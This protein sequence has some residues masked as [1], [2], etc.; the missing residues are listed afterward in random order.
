M[1]DYLKGL[2]E[3]QKEAVLHINGP[4]MIVAGAGSG[5]TKVL[6]TRI[7]HLMNQGVDAFNILALTFTNKA[8]AE[9]KER[10]EKILGN[11]EARNL[12]IG[13]FHSVFARI[14]RGEAHRIGYPNNFTIYDTDDSRSVLKTVINEM[15]LDD[16][17]YKP[18]VVGN[19]IS[20]AKNALVGPAEY[21]TDYYIQQE[22]MRAN[23]P[24][25]AQI[26]AAYAAR[27][28]KNGAMDFDDLLLKMYELLKNFPEALHKYQHKFKYILIDEYQDT[29]A[30]Q[31][32]ITKL[33]AAAHENICVV[34]DD[35]QSIYSFRGA[36]IENILQF[37][38]DYDDV[39]VVKL[40]QN[41]RSSQS[42]LNVANEVISN[43][44]G[45]I[46]K[47]LWTE[48]SA[49]EKISLVRTMT[50]N[51]EG[52]FTADTIQ[53]Q[54]LRNH[55]HN[56]D[57]AILY[58]TNAQSRAFEESLRRM[59]IAYRIYGGVSFYQ[60]K[61]IKD[62][63]AYMRVIVNTNDEVSLLR[64][65]NYPARGIGKTT[66]EKCAIYAN[67]QNIPLFEVVSRAGEFGFKGG[68]LE[69]LSNFVTM[70]RYFQSLLTDKNAYDVAV[71]VGKHT[72][73]TKE[74]FADKTTEGLARYENI[75]E[76]LNSIK[77]WTESPLNEEDG[78][79]GE[80]S[81][82][83]YLQQITLLT[84]ADDDKENSD[85]VKLMTIHAAKGLEFGCVFVAGIEEM[86]FPNAMSINT[87]EELEEERRLFY[88]A[89]TRAKHRLWLT[90]ANTRYR[91]GQLVQNEPSRF[92]EEMPEQYI[93]KSYAGGGA[94]NNFSS[95]MGSAFERMQR[96]FGF[97]S[98]AADAE[99][100][101]G[102]PPAKKT[103]SK[104]EYLPIT[105]PSSKVVE[106]KPGAD[107]V[108]SDT[109]NLQAGQ[110]VE[111]QKFGFG[112]V[113]KVEGSAHNPVA[114]IVFKLNGEKKIMLNYAKLRI[115]S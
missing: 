6:T 54:K 58:R 55:Y 94:R 42:I 11:S 21:A 82:G 14:L 109:S 25:I 32:Q 56:R 78:E 53:E 24:A 108:A 89:I 35:A 51:D 48:N 18:S 40:E 75:Q 23:R 2:N 61:E 104:P 60:R 112:T 69:Q 16:K 67:E 29:N 99:K 28:F 20:S 26:Y 92:I 88:V 80:K 83:A 12:Y 30:V 5:K 68:T 62:F 50:D 43:N 110:E 65:I 98:Q 107:F 74:L 47:N 13:T 105:P 77:E 38:K 41:Y 8:A 19:R 103:N 7:A 93:D 115:I 79:V 17:H 59:G 1:H 46:P 97:G 15:N 72:N 113:A 85:V 9:M 84:D 37:Q 34:G 63:L 101:Y 100:K 71:Q 44:K 49:G 87:R 76:L 70:I 102:P 73:I 64:I 52:K 27:C 90:Y 111:H 66:L 36:T 33:L 3:Q 45:Q 114:T 106:H 22:D 4:L 95:D 86:L 57:F 31:Y 39:K 96:G 91:F 10:I 81:L